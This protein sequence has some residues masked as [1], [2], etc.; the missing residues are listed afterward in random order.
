MAFPERTRRT[1]KPK[2]C[3]DLG[4]MDIYRD[5][6]VTTVILHQF[7]YKRVSIGR[8]G[9]GELFRFCSRCLNIIAEHKHKKVRF[10][11]K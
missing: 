5:G 3:Q 4:L 8:H 2:G 10:N 9:D 1:K 11:Q 6:D 7:C